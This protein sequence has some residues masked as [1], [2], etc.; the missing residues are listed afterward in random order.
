MA[1]RDRSQLPYELNHGR[2]NRNEDDRWQNKITERGNHFNRGFGCLFFGA[3]PAFRAE[4][5]GMHPKGLGNAGAEAIGLNQ[6]THES[7]NIVN[8][9]AVYN[10]I[11]ADHLRPLAEKVWLKDTRTFHVQSWLNQVGSAKLSRNTLKHV[12]SVISG[13]FTLAKQQDYFQ[14]ENPARDTAI[15]PKAAEPQE[16]YAYSLEEVQT[17]CP[18]FPNLLLRPSQWRHS[19]DSGMARYR[20]YSGRTIGVANCLLRV[21]S[22]MGRSQ[23]QRLGKAAL[24][25]R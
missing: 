7:S 10:D 8:A 4:G 22:G 17:F 2:P 6:R 3:L 16:T 19:W 11:W 21:R 15:N 1:H 5:V 12:K 18:F 24:Q 13:I 9:G 20:A 14:G 23:T 25:F